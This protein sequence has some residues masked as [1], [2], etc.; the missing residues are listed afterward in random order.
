ME[1]VLKSDIKSVI[2]FDISIKRTTWIG[3]KSINSQKK[4]VL[5]TSDAW[6]MIHLSH[7]PSD[8]AYH[9]VN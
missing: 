9:I 5:G 8:P 3:H 7:R 2:R 1:A 6:S 4:V